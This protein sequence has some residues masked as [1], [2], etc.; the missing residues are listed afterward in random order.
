MAHRAT[1]PGEAIAPASGAGGGVAEGL[2][3]AGTRKRRPHNAANGALQPGPSPVV[4]VAVAVAVAGEEHS[5]GGRPKEAKERKPRP[6]AAAK[7]KEEEVRAC[8]A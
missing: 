5:G 3:E 8:G 1:I 4:A 6:T 7:R 2:G